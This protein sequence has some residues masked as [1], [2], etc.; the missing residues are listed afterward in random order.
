MFVA[1]RVAESMQKKVTAKRG[2]IDTLQIKIHWLEERL[3][4]ALKV[5]Y[6]RSAIFSF[7]FFFIIIFFKVFICLF[8]SYREGL[9][10]TISPSM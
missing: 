1:V 4:A 5:L 7:D 3:D 10:C 8:I 9:L 6:T 2:E